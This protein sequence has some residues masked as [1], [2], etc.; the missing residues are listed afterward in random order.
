MTS[1]HRTITCTVRDQKQKNLTVTGYTARLEPE[2][3]R[4]SIKIIADAVHVVADSLSG[5]FRAESLVYRQGNQL[6][7]AQ[8][9]DDLPASG[10]DLVEFRASRE[11]RCDASLLLTAHLS[12]GTMEKAAYTFSIFQDWTA[13]N[14]RLREE[15]HAR[16]CAKR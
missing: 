15:V 1:L 8:N 9:W 5:L 14:I 7:Q 6:V 13:G 3:A 4:P 11:I 10:I 16:N 12:D 2:I